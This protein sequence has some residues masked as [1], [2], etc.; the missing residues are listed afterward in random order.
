[1]EKGKHSET[2][3][4]EEYSWTITQAAGRSCR[5][6]PDSNVVVWI[7]YISLSVS[8]S[9]SYVCIYIY[10]CV[11]VCVCVCGYVCE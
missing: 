1:L 4:K 3:P 11:C 2:K 8:L 9:H 5:G 7:L 10:M 6:R